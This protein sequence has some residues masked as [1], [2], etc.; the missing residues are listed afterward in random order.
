MSFSS[1]SLTLLIL[2]LCSRLKQYSCFCIL[3][4]PLK[5][6]LL[7]GKSPIST[8]PQWLPQ[9]ISKAPIIQTSEDSQ[10]QSLKKPLHGSFHP[11]NAHWQQ[12]ITIRA[13]TIS[14]WS[15]SSLWIFIITLLAKESLSS[16]FYSEVNYLPKDS[17]QQ[18]RHNSK[19]K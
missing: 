5:F 14:A 17:Q 19:A 16:P 6:K 2:S 9:H 15:V 18:Q 1:A 7:A 4:S 8:N 3:L 12:I 11:L 13:T 10:F